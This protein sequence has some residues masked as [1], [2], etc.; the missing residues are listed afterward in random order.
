[1][2]LQCKHCPNEFVSVDLREQVALAECVN[3]MLLHYSTKHLEALTKAQK[4]SQKAIG[5]VI[6]VAMM[7]NLVVIPDGEAFAQSEV[8]RFRKEVLALLGLEKEDETKSILVAS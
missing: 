4:E 8:E 1:M 3:A 7:N 5:E 2:K 6:W